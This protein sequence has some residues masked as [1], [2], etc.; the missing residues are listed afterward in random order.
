M[1]EILFVLLVVIL[2]IAG[3][4]IFKEY[5]GGALKKTKSWK[6]K[7]SVIMEIIIAAMSLIGVIAVALGW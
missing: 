4:L 5:S 2:A 3:Y 1:N 7:E 6:E